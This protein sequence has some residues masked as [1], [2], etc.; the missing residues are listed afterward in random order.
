MWPLPILGLR[1]GGLPGLP[2]DECR[3]ST[4]VL[5]RAGVLSVRR[6]RVSAMSISAV[7]VEAVPDPSVEDVRGFV[8]DLEGVL[9]R[10]PRVCWN[11]LAGRELLGHVT[12]LGKAASR[13]A[14]VRLA[15]LAAAERQQAA[16]RT[17]ARSTGAWLRTTGMRAGHAHREVELAHDLQNLDATR[18][19]LGEG[20]IS[21]DHAQVIAG[22]MAG[23]SDQVDD[24]G[25]AEVERRLVDQ[26]T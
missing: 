25:R 20:V 5:A 24:A 4:T 1:R 19:A 13:V 11:A 21:P 2:V 12:R 26:A 10:A 22:T 15:G 3:S 9:A 6:V 7:A 23:L 8:A 14:A 17:G 16:R 18:D